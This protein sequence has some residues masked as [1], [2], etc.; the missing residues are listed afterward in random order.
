MKLSKK[1]LLALAILPVATL[2]LSG[3]GKQTA[4]TKSVE[5]KTQTSQSADAKAPGA[6]VPVQA[7]ETPAKP[8]LEPLPADDKQA[9]DTELSNIDKDLKATDGSFSSTDLSNANLGL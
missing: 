6:P 1:R 5:D 3:C 4:P 2:L 7:I 8:Q 9:I